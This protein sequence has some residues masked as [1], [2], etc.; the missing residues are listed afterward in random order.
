M[1]GLAF[2]LAI[3]AL[4]LAPAAMAADSPAEHQPGYAPADW[5]KRPTT[6]DLMG[7]WPKEALRKGQGGKAVLD[8]AVT[9]RGDLTT[10]R[11]VEESPAGA[12]FGGAALALTSQIQMK[13]ATLNGAP[14]EGHVRLPVTFPSFTPSKEPELMR[15]VLPG[16]LMQAAPTYAEVA[17]AFPEKAKAKGLAGR[18]ALNCSVIQTGE[19]K[20]CAVISETPMGIGFAAAAKALIPKFRAPP[21][22]PNLPSTTGAYAQ[23]TVNFP[24]E[25]IDATAVPVIGKP[26]W[27]KLPTAEQLSAAMSKARTPGQIRVVL[28]CLIA[29]DG[30]TT[31]CKVASEDP[32]GQG[33]GDATLSLA[34]YFKM[35]VWTME[36]LPTIGARVN[37][38]VRFQ[39]TAAPPPKP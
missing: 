13:P 31:D 20:R 4:A 37:I 5:L 21:S 12:G 17:A 39:M 35:T 15:A 34:P 14:V 27:V 22:A 30:S 32:A 11:V 2:G 36:G 19:L 8:C 10:C 33:Y 26:S 25:M 1:R 3:A 9:V 29:P 16:V 38:P 18:V 24:K 23:I 7:V 6:D 28:D